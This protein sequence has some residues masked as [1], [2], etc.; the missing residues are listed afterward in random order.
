MH[1]A[2]DCA[3][4]LVFSLLASYSLIVDDPIA[5]QQTLR[6]V[7]VYCVLDSFYIVVR[8]AS[9]PGLVRLCTVL[10]HHLMVVYVVHTATAVMIVPLTVSTLVEFSS[11]AL[12]LHR[13]LK[14]TWSHLF[15]LVAWVG[16]RLML[17]TGLFVYF[18]GLAFDPHTLLCLFVFPALSYLWTFEAI[19]WV[20]FSKWKRP[21]STLPLSSLCLLLS[22]QGFEWYMCLMCLVSLAYHACA[23]NPFL[24]RL[25]GAM[26]TLTILL[27]IY[28]SIHPAILGSTTVLSYA[29]KHVKEALFI[30]GFV[31]WVQHGHQ[32]A[33][34]AGLGIF[35]VAFTA[36]CHLCIDWT[37][38]HRCTA[39]CYMWHLN[40]A[41]MLS[42]LWHQRTRNDKMS[43][44]DEWGRYVWGNNP[45]HPSA[46]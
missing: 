39:W 33:F 42:L 9:Q 5:C 46:S 20:R 3:V 44:G 7:Q 28:P 31:T 40:C 37:L 1:V 41:L 4:T 18:C 13:I 21:P 30:V 23:H 34:E 19:G 17:Q 25:D 24:K 12:N 6:L 8:P 27:T 38:H 45:S 11:F 32:S 36:T 2:L 29:N 15:F 16:A 43:G 22:S 14:T 10:L 26:V 35:A